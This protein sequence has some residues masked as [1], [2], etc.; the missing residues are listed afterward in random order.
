MDPELLNEI[1]KIR[2]AMY[3]LKFHNCFERQPVNSVL[4]DTETYHI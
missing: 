3:K 2:V 4:N 1:F